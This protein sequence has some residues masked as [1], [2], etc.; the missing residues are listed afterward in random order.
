MEG[1]IDVKSQDND[2]IRLCKVPY[3]RSNCTGSKGN[4]DGQA[5]AHV[6]QSPATM[7]SFLKRR[8]LAIP[9]I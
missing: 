2:Y 5:I 7:K 8:I 3:C 1:T 9:D 6:T 4:Y